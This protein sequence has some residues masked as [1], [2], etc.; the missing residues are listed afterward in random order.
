MSKSGVYTLTCIVNKKVYVGCTTDLKQRE[1]AHFSEL[2]CNKHNIKD[3]QDDYNKYGKGAFKYEILIKCKKRF[4]RSEENYWC[5]MLDSHNPLHGYNIANTNPN[6]KGLPLKSSIE[7]SSLKRCVPVMMLSA[8]GEFIKR[9]NSCKDAAIELKTNSSSIS[10]VARGVRSHCKGYV[11]IYEDKYDV[12]KNYSIKILRYKRNILM[13]DEDMKLIKEFES[14]EE[15]AKYVQGSQ[16]SL[17]RTLNNK[18]KTY[19]KYIWK[20]GN[21][22]SGLYVYAYEKSKQF[23]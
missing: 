13:Y 7:K 3:L 23:I 16:V 11:F 8:E 15:A 12:S 20:Y 9:F 21:K 14:T 10:A 19:K 17:W 2:K 18:R 1:S 4:L 5:N 22:T 6:G